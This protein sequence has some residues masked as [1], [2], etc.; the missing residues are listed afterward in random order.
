MLHLY[1]T[2]LIYGADMRN[3]HASFIGQ[4][5]QHE[6]LLKVVTWVWLPLPLALKPLLDAAATRFTPAGPSGI[7]FPPNY[8]L[9][10]VLVWSLIIGTAVGF[11][12]PRFR[13]G[14]RDASN[15]AMQ[16]CG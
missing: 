4:Q 16:T 10:S 7:N 12:V 1:G 5:P 15:Q 8:F 9:Y 6:F 3:A 13:R 11:F 14:P 2:S